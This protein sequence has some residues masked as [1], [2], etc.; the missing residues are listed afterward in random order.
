MEAGHLNIEDPE[1]KLDVTNMHL[2]LDNGEAA[3]GECD[4]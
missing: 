1:F 3:Y 2:I 4:C